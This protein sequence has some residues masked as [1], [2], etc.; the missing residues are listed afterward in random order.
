LPID[1]RALSLDGAL[2][3]G[4][5]VSDGIGEIGS[6][7]ESSISAAFGYN[8]PVLRIR[9]ADFLKS[10]RVISF[11]LP[12]KQV[13]PIRQYDLSVEAGC[14]T[15]SVDVVNCGVRS[16]ECSVNQA[17]KVPGGENILIE[18]VSVESRTSRIGTLPYKRR[19]LDVGLLP[20]SEHTSF[21][22]EAE[23]I[24]HLPADKAEL[25]AVFRNIPIELVSRMRFI[26]EGNV[27]FYTL[28]STYGRTMT[29]VHDMAAIR[30]TDSGEIH[31]IPHRTRFQAVSLD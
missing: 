11:R 2:A 5:H 23:A 12:G 26:A 29:R 24:K 9:N 18:N 14:R 25:L 4:T 15:F 1:A 8:K 21:L 19:S 6:R 30:N 28:F 16:V 20:E 27:I 31:L 7:R 22:R 13:S 10:G 17:E 3:L